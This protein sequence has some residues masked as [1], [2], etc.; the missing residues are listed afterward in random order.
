[1]RSHDI[2]MILLFLSAYCT[3][4]QAQIEMTCVV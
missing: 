4:A 1:M 3:L 2:C